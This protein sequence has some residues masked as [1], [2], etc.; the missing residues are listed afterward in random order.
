[1]NAYKML[2]GFGTSGKFMNH[3]SRGRNSCWK[4]TRFDIRKKVK[5]G[6]AVS[7]Y[8]GV[9]QFHSHSAYASLTLPHLSC[10]EYYLWK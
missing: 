5:A 4:Q 1:M 3:C 2:A 7:V 9:S 6:L 10:L 8:R